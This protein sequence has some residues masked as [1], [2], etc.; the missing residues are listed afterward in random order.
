ML[1]AFG[2]PGASSRVSRS[3]R[4]LRT[5]TASYNVLV[6]RATNKSKRLFL[7]LPSATFALAF[8]LLGWVASHSIAYAL[9]GLVPHG[10]Q[11]QH[12]HGYLEVLKLAG[13]SLLVLAF[14]FALR[15]FLRHGSLGEWLHYGGSAGTSKQ[16]A[17]ATVLPAGVFVAIEYLERIVAGAGASPPAK[18]LVVGVFVQLIVG[19]LCLGLVRMTFRVAKRVIVCIASGLLVRP[20]QPAAGLVLESIAFARSSCPMADSKSGRAPPVSGV[21]L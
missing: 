8:I 6:A 7:S 5:V 9:V 13:G 21:Y 10:H 15:V 4:V 19:L 3:R 2:G 16:V 11:E 17:L 12:M 18:L 14:G 1:E 20:G